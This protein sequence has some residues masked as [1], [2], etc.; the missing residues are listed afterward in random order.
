M[1]TVSQQQIRQLNRYRWVVWIPLAFAFLASYFQ[2]TAT[3]VVADNLMREFSIT[4]AADIGGL[5]SVYFYIYA[6][7]QLPSGIL[8]D[9]LGPRRTVLLALTTATAGAVIFALA[10]NIPM[11]YVGRILS[12]LG[13]SMIYVCIVKIHAEWFRTREFT[14]M[15]GIVVVAGSIG[16][17]LAST[18]LALLVDKFGWRFAFLTLGAYSLLAMIACWLW[19]KNRPIELGLP[20]IA[21]VEVYE[22]TV[23]TVSESTSNNYSVIKNLKIVVSNSATWWPFLASVTTYG[24]YMAF[25]GLWAVPYFMQI[26]GMTRVA[27]SNYILA[28]SIGTLVGG[29]LI[30]VL[31]DRIALRRLP[32]IVFTGTYLVLWLV[33]TVWNGGKPPVWAWYPL[34]FGIGLGMSGVNLNVACG[35]EVNPPEVTGLVAGL[36]NS[37]PFVGGA[38]LQPLFGWLLD[39]HWQG[40]IVNGVRVYPLTAYQNAF[41]V[42]AIILGFGLL[43]TCLI[44]ETKGLNIYQ[45]R[46]GIPKM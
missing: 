28:L 20:T 8:A 5:A 30:G 10:P 3:G 16:F 23:K 40:T 17:L 18:P 35:K 2:R 26:Y 32:N 39:S 6:A 41:W 46:A 44:K 34:C 29:P 13:V 19:V 24:V 36:V 1:D 9:T 11:L 12:S 27:A 38:I 43:F 15:V 33:L 45:D 4:R 37:G 42:C 22:G 31:S 14:T 7:M 21:A 25:M